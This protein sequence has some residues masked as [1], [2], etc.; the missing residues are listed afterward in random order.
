MKSAIIVTVIAAS[1]LKKQLFYIIYAEKSNKNS[2]S[3][4]IGA[5]KVENCLIPSL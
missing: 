1:S 5:K 2:I 4:V 3:F